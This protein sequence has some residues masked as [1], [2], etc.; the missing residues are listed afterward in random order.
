M[1]AK[2]ALALALL[3]G[4]VLTVFNCMK[5]IGYSNIGREIP[6]TIEKPFG[7]IVSRVSKESTNRYG[8]PV[9]YTEYR[10]NNTEANKEGRQKLIYFCKKEID[11]VPKTDKQS[12]A[13][14]ALKQVEMF[15]VV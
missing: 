14:K 15:P 2:C 5:E 6:R 7:V 8:D 9:K 1:T 12:K 13:Y 3:E 11:A 4:R 10:L